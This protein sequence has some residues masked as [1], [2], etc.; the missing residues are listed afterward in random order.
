MNHLHFVQSLETKQG[1]G[2]GRAALDLHSTWLKQGMAS[3]LYTT[4][5]ADQADAAAGVFTRKRM[6]PEKAY[7]AP[8]L[9]AEAAA[10]VA[11]ADVLHAHGMYVAPNWIFG[12]QARRQGVPLVVHVHGFFEPWILARSRL[13]KR[14]AAL[15]FESENWRAAKLWRALTAVEADQ[16]RGQ[17]ITSPIVVAP[18][19]VDVAYFQ[20]AVTALPKPKRR[21]LFLGRL[22]PKKGVE[23]LIQAWAQLGP[24]YNDWELLIVGPDEGGYR[25]V[26]EKELVAHGASASIA[27]SGAV[28]GLEKV[29]LL[30]SADL[31][32]LPSHSEGFSVAVL[33]ALA[34]GVPVLISDRCN[35][36]E[37]EPA[38]AGWLC[39][40]EAASILAQLRI[41][42]ATTEA[43][44]RERGGAGL[45][46]VNEKYSWESVARIIAGACS[47]LQ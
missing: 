34:S 16:I 28:F 46:L 20:Q 13:K 42:L 45:K 37:V 1:G 15:L 32:V 40:P 47:Q 18:N 35:F 23:L 26:L 36:D 14:A 9:L 27:I 25:A 22:H 3:R 24:A 6:P 12:R 4:G 44:R 29:R 10:A 31:F 41:A 39:R 5:A 21:A 43:E 8:K 19:G 11:W 2:L 17:G 33:E 30:R 38:G 7:F